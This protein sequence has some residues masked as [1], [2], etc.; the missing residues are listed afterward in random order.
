V[1]VNITVQGGPKAL[2]RGEAQVA[3]ALAR[4]VTLGARRL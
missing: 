1:T 3:Q 2:L 4:A